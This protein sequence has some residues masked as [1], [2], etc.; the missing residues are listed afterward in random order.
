MDDTGQPKMKR[1]NPSL[2]ALRVSTGGFTAHE[3]KL[4]SVLRALIDKGDGII[5]AIDL[6]TDQ[7]AR[8]TAQ[9]SAATSAAEKVLKF[10]K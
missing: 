3:R 1:P 9:L 8:E 4:R 10:K 2:D 7:F 5:E 6:S